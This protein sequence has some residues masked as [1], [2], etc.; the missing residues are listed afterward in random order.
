M[1][2]RNVAAALA[3]G[4]L[5]FAASKLLRRRAARRRDRV[6]LYFEDG[7]MVSFAEGSDEGD[8]L[9]PLALGVLADLRG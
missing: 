6:D 8:R 7:S 1:K 9:L 3:L 4:A 2:R 5:S